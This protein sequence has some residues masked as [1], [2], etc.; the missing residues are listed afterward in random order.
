MVSKFSEKDLRFF[1]L[2]KIH[3]LEVSANHEVH[4]A[5]MMVVKRNRRDGMEIPVQTGLAGYVLEVSVAQVLE[6]L[7][8]SETNHQHVEPSIVVE[9]EPECRRGSVVPAVAV[10]HPGFLRDVGECE[11]ALVAVQT[12]FAGLGQVGEKEVVA[13]EVGH[14]YRGAKCRVT[15]HDFGVRIVKHP[16]GTPVMNAGLVRHAPALTRWCVGDQARRNQ[17]D[18]R[19]Y[20]E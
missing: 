5:V 18:A 16:V 12:V 4:V 2:E 3:R 8:V 1:K 19:A 6:Q 9:I 13:I 17:R 20:R 10:R 7:V 11:V 15:S 14:R